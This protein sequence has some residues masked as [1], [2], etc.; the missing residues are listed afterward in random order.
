[1]SIFV[2]CSCL[3]L[4]IVIV[5]ISF[6][7]PQHHYNFTYSIPS[8]VYFNSQKIKKQKTDKDF[9]ELSSLK[10]VFPFM[11]IVSSCLFYLSFLIFSINLS[12]GFF[13]FMWSVCSSVLSTTDFLFYL[14]PNK[15]IFF[16]LCL[17]FSYFLFFD[18][19]TLSYNIVSGLV[20]FSVFYFLFF[21]FPNGI[22]GG[23]V[24]LAGLIGFSFGY[25]R[26]LSA[27]LI[28]SVLALLYGV[29]H[30]MYKKRKQVSSL[31][32]PFGPF[33]FAGTWI[34]LLGEFFN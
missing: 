26:S 10:I 15:I 19:L 23:D 32:L 24:K 11:V 7:Y 12:L 5:S 30:S 33:L 2:L 9:K 29:L 6:S 14:L 16:F 34:V 3:F 20:I 22:G 27:F 31:V 17:S 8:L 21:L 25:Q 28:A 4:S 13:L 18:S 1:M